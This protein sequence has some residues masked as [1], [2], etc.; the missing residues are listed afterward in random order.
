MW[1]ELLPVTAVENARLTLRFQDQISR[2]P[3]AW[4]IRPVGLSL[5]LPYF[6]GMCRCGPVQGLP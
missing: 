4:Q 3:I 6:G 2:K 1:Y 5:H